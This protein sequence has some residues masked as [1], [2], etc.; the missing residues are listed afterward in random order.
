MKKISKLL[1]TLVLILALS[2]TAFGQEDNFV[3]DS[4]D[5]WRYNE[6]QKL[7]SG[8]VSFIHAIY[9]G[10][11]NNQDIDRVGIGTNRPLA[12]LHVMRKDV[13]GKE[14]AGVDA[15]M[16]IT[17]GNKTLHLEGNGIDTAVGTLY[18]NKNYDGNVSLVEGSG[19]VGIGTASPGARLDVNGQ[20]QIRGGTPDT[21]KV[22]TASNANGLATWQALPANADNLGN[23]IA[24]QNV[25]LNGNWL[26]GDGESEGVSVANNGKVSIGNGGTPISKMQF[27]SVGNGTSGSAGS[28]GTVN[29]PTSFPVTPI[30]FLNVQRPDIG[31]TSATH[32]FVTSV[33]GSSFSWQGAFGTDPGAVNR[34]S[35][36][37]IGP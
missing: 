14:I 36:V 11:F 26:S 31:S 35:W 25:Q 3:Y 13:M 1:S 34:L 22:L 37:A 19:N 12:K 27:G 30:I 2:Q 9:L 8:I 28:T 4:L 16:K 32:A 5:A 15:T 21:G 23:H 10:K 33:S 7:D 20:V 17:S 6:W 29:F 18:L 24:T